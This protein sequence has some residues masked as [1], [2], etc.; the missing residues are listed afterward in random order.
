[1]DHDALAAPGVMLKRQASKEAAKR[2]VTI[3]S[4]AD[5]PLKIRYQGKSLLEGGGWHES[6][7]QPVCTA[8]EAKAAAGMAGRQVKAAEVKGAAAPIESLWPMAEGDDAARVATSGSYAE[9]DVNDE[10]LEVREVTYAERDAKGR[11]AAV[12][13]SDDDEEEEIELQEEEDDDE[14]EME[15]QEEEHEEDMEVEEEQGDD[16]NDDD[17]DDDDDDDEYRLGKMGPEGDTE[18]EEEGGA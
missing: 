14:E 12:C 18:E 8:P 5:H 9:D 17:D 16:D 3:P 2:A 15:V 4:D 7:E 6:P 10:V 1:M 13:L 11:A